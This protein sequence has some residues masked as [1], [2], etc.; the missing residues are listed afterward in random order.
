MEVVTTVS[1]LDGL[2]ARPRVVGPVRPAPAP[3]P[4]GFRGV[5]PIVRFAFYGFIVSV[6]FEYPERTFPLEVHTLT[7]T[8][9]IF[10][11]LLQPR[12][13]YARIPKALGWFA[14][15]LGVF[16]LLGMFGEH[17]GEA[18]HLAL[19]LALILMLSIAAYN[20][21]RFAAIAQAALGGFVISGTA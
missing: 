16:V 9:F 19:N 2:A 8:L 11:T 14:G 10:V 6:P 21:M 3:G 1:D 7:G 17:R 18:L 15:Y 12:V 4:K 20:L 5:H 13:C